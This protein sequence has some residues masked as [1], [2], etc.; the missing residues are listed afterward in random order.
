MKPFLAALALI[1]APALAVDFAAPRVAP[2]DIAVPD[3]ARAVF[4]GALAISPVSED[5]GGLSGLTMEGPRSLLA[6]SDRG[7]WIRMEIDIENGR[8]TGVSG[9]SATPL[10]D[11]GG[12]RLDPA[13]ADAEGAAA[14]PGG[15]VWVSFERDHRLVFYPDPDA[16]ADVERRDRSWE[17]FSLNSGLEALASAPDG[18]LWAI[19]ERSGALDRPFPVYVEDGGGWIVK[20]LPR[21]GDYLPTGADFGPDGRLYVAERAFSFIG[22]FRFRLRRLSWADG[23][24]PVAEETLLELGAASRI[25]NI[26]GVAVFRENGATYAL[27]VSDDNFNPL[28]RNVL[29]LFEV[30]D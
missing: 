28:Q 4:R 19:R 12:A 9:V 17:R 7:A 21:H 8:L 26:E 24:E 6:V 22:G 16:P 25:D 10:Q 15:G 11:A 30:P 3:E 20:S 5:F 2:F 14:A 1:A 13:A 27:L 23:P 29:A 18:R